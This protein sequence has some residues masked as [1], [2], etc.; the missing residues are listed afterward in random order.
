[1]FW[2][3][4]EKI[5]SVTFWVFASVTRGFALIVL[6]NSKEDTLEA[7]VAYLMSWV[8][9]DFSSFLSPVLSSETNSR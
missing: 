9:S 7:F 8:N 4:V 5:R 2:S 1:M 3:M 6:M